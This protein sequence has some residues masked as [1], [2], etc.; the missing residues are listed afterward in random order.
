[1]TTMFLQAA[2]ALYADD[3]HLR[4]LLCDMLDYGAAVQN[5]FDYKTDDLASDYIAS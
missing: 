3:E 2:A 4:T 5:L 1:M